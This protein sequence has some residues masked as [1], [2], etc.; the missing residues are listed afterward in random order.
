MKLKEIIHIPYYDLNKITGKELRSAYTR[1]RSSL[2]SR[3]GTFERHGNIKGVPSRLREGLPR[4][5]SGLS[6]RQMQDAIASAGAWMRGANSTNRGY[7]NMI[8]KRGEELNRIVGADII[9][10]KAD[11]DK[12]GDFMGAMQTRAG[13]MWKKDSAQVK[14]MYLQASRFGLN[15]N[16]FI[17]NYKYWEKNLKKLSEYEGDTSSFKSLKDIQKELK[18]ETIASFYRENPEEKGSY[19]TRKR[20]GSKK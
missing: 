12:Y 8:M 18:L 4:I 3:V 14:E 19:G 6:D 13:E 15:P 11:Y 5:S 20:K 16:N 1:V 2:N 17:K 10:S 9:K 7:E